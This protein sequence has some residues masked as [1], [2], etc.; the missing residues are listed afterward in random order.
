MQPIY[1]LLPPAAL[2]TP[3]LY[4]TTVDINNNVQYEVRVQWIV[5]D[6]DTYNDVEYVVSVANSSSPTHMDITTNQTQITLN[7][8]Y[9]VNY[10]VAVTAQRCGRNVTSEPSEECLL[11]YPGIYFTEQGVSYKFKHNTK[12]MTNN[13]Q[14]LFYFLLLTSSK[15]C[16][17]TCCLQFQRNHPSPHYLPQYSPQVGI[18]LF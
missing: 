9:G 12:S 13:G 4:C 11:Y 2:S 18:V 15:T 10:T 17:P 1:I 7:V 6:T 8:F 16:I 3:Q 14:C 5:N